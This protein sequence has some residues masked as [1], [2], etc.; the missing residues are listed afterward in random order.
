MQVSCSLCSETVD[1]D[2]IDIH[3][4]EN[5]PK[6]IVT[7]DFCEFPLPAIDLAEHQVVLMKNF[8][9]EDSFDI[10][11]CTNFSL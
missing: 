9:L 3:T 11:L 7:C 2:I 5:C 10:C 6:R 1:R 4:G 8:G